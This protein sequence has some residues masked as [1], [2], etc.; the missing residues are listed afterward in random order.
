MMSRTR[1]S[2][3]V[4]AA[5]ATLAL[6]PKPGEAS[7]I[8]YAFRGKVER[9]LAG[10]EISGQVTSP[11]S[12]AVLGTEIR[13]DDAYEATIRVEPMAPTSLESSP[14]T[15]AMGSYVFPEA[16]SWFALNFADL[17]IE[18][19]PAGD[20]LLLFVYDSPTGDGFTG[21][22]QFGRLSP[23]MTASVARFDLWEG[24]GDALVGTDLP[25]ELLLSAFQGDGTA[26]GSVLSLGLHFFFEDGS[27]IE[28]VSSIDAIDV[29]TEDD[30]TPDGPIGLA[31]TDPSTPV[32]EPG[33]M[34]LFG[35]MTLAV[36]A[37]RR[38]RLR[39]GG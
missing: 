4:L 25:I 36:L 1:R 34:T 7:V 29:T 24:T 15:G 30:S 26:P 21:H 35:G 18:R 39:A 6:L 19:G 10:N 8:E 28:V 23:T 2:S 11:D 13:L 17:T 27:W 16:R 33:M 9:I 3:M 22:Q 37:R 12:I 31:P 5:F 32:P 14:T 38:L 20:D